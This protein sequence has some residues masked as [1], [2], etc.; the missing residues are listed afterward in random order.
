MAVDY[1]SYNIRVNNLCPGCFKTDMT[2]G[3]FSDEKIRDNIS[4]ER[5]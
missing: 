2:R 5:C 1:G 3:S 4:S